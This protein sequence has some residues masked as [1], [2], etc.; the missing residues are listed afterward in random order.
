MFFFNACTAFA[1]AS[2]C[3][4]YKKQEDGYKIATF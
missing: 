1:K 4:L 2:K 3:T